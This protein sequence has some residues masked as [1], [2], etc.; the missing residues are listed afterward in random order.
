[1][2][3]L[4]GHDCPRCHVELFIEVNEEVE[5]VDLLICKECWGVG[6]AAKSMELVMSEG[7]LLDTKR[8]EIIKSSGD[9]KCPMCSTIMDEIELDIPENIREK[10]SIIGQSDLDINNVIID[11]CNSCP[12]FWFDA[13][14]LDLL[15]GIKPRFR[16]GNRDPTKVRLLE[17]QTLTEEDL[18]KKKNTRN[19]LGLVTLAVAIYGFVIGGILVKILAAL[20]GIG[21]LIAIFSKNPEQSLVKGTC[22]KCLKPDKLLAWNCQSGGCWAHICADCESVGS[23]PVEAYAKTLGTVAVGTVV[24]GVAVLALFAAM[25][26][27]GAG[28]DLFGPSGGGGKKKAKAKKIDMLLCRECTKRWRDQQ[29]DSESK[30]YNDSGIVSKNYKTIKSSEATGDGY[31]NHKDSRTDRKCQ[32]MTFRGGN[33]CYVHKE[34]Y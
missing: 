2:S 34:L 23:D 26:S 19:G 22:E 18:K 33:Y 32:R 5:G 9:C 1:M 17:D 15:N 27:G 13:G 14:E 16:G 12:T 10:I 11:S 30:E 20:L 3:E 7:S 25:E 6:V 8:D 24:A 31:C 4:S 21:G 28:L 29:D